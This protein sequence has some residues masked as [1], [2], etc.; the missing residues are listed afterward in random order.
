[1]AANNAQKAQIHI[2]KDRLG[3]TDEDYRDMLASYGVTTS[4]D[5]TFRDA[6]EFIKALRR[7]VLESG[8]PQPHRTGYASRAQKAMLWNMWQQISRQD[9]KE[10]MTEA[11]RHFVKARF[12]IDN[13]E[14]LPG[15]AVSKIKKTLEAMGAKYAG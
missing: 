6:G 7:K 3:L 14:W 15:S 5:L 11:F 9:T 12:R 8:A 13:V 1:M 2:L 10:K 4:K